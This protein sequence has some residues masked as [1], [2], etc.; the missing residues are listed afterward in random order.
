MNGL[1]CILDG[2][3]IDGGQ[4]GD[5]S[6]DQ[7]RPICQQANYRPTELRQFAVRMA[8]EEGVEHLYCF[9]GMVLLKVLHAEADRVPVVYTATQEGSKRIDHYV[10]P[11]KTGRAV[12]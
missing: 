11:M 10:V 7:F 5:Q 12:K 8:F 9:C 2:Q 3:L 1:S 6:V 4:V